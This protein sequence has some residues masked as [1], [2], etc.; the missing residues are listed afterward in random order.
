M[1]EATRRCRAR[2]ARARTSS[3]LSRRQL[4][5]VVELVVVHQVAESLDRAVHLLRDRLAP[6][7]AG[8]RPGTNRVT[9]APSAQIP[10]D[11]FISASLIEFDLVA[12][13]PQKPEFRRDILTGEWVAINGSRRRGRTCPSTD[14]PFCV[15]GL[16]APDPY[17]V[18]WFTEP[19]AGV[20]ARRPGRLARRPSDRVARRAAR[21]RSC[22]SRPTTTR[23]SRRSAPSRCARSSTSGPSAPR[24]C[25][26]APRSSTCS[27]SRTAAPRSARRSTI[28]TARST[29]T[30]SCRP[31]PRE[32]AAVL[33]TGRARSARG[34]TEPR[35]ASSTR[36]G[37]GGS[38]PFASGCPY[39]MRI[40]PAAARRVAARARRRAARRARR[41]A[42]RRARPLRPALRRCR[43]PYL[44]WFHQRRRRDRWHVTHVAPPLRAAGTMR[45]VASGEVGSGTL[46]NPVVPEAAAEALR[47]PDA[48]VPRA[49]PRQPDRRPHRLQRRL[50]AAARDRPRRDV[51]AEPRDDGRIR[52]RAPTVGHGRRRRSPPTAP[53]TRRRSSPE[54]GRYVA[55]VVRV[56]RRARPRAGR[57][58]RRRRVAIPAGAG[59]S[60]S[61]ALEVAVALALCDAAGFCAAAA[62]ARAR[63]QRRRARRHGRAVRDHGPDGVDRR[64]RATT[65][66]C[67]TAAA[68]EIEYVP[69]PDGRRRARRPLGQPRALDGSAY[70]E[71]RAACEAVAARLGIPALRDATL[72]AGRRRAAR[73][74]R[75]LRERARARGR[76]RAARR[77]PRRRSAGCSRRATRACATTSRSRRRSSTA[78]ST[79]LE[80]AGALGA[81]L[82]GAGF[83]GC[84]VALSRPRQTN[85]VVVGAS[86]RLP[87]GHRPRADGVRLPR[88]RG[89]GEAVRRARAAAERA[90]RGRHRPD[91]RGGRADRAGRLRPRRLRA[92]GADP[93]HLRQHRPLLREGAAAASGPDLPA[94]PASAARPGQPGQGGDV[95]LPPRRGLPL[96]LG[97]AD[98][99]ARPR[100]RPASTTTCGTRS[101]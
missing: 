30:R 13:F 79:P 98:G 85:N 14:C 8:S 94:A 89:S 41:A 37:L 20:R 67:S 92:R 25:S 19:L 34:R 56:A 3:R 31:R 32:E 17:D 38:V 26:R 73:A 48:A 66:C 84:V 101:A 83:G 64:P 76:R 39:G 1:P 40:A 86:G 36:T 4:A 74:A 49:R 72:G 78:S 15:G 23:R 27:C 9:M 62:R 6:A 28:R 52:A 44:L 91:A 51:R 29:A 10:S 59:L 21:P 81:R 11:V 53:T 45:Y 71:R 5:G 61:A 42:R 60:S 33:A 55:G 80:R 47:E 90:R 77:R 22:S 24:R 50:R 2:R 63:R 100:R 18:R 99:G 70:A 95:P 82:T 35:G 12:T 7:R 46:S 54:W 93:L 75:R 97:R 65:R 16:E 87:R 68:L 69:M 57:R 88:R 96:R 43:F 58:R